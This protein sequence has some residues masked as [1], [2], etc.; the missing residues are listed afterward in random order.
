MAALELEAKVKE[1]EEAAPW[2]AIEFQG[3]LEESKPKET[4]FSQVL[5]ITFCLWKYSGKYHGYLV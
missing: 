5:K 3:K 2:E 4:V 1:V